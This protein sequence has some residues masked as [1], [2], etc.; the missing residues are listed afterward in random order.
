MKKK[1]KIKL[2]LFIK[3]AE[4]IRNRI[5]ADQLSLY[6]K[7]LEIAKREYEKIR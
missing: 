4:K 1:D 5:P 7:N 2:F 6:D 3:N